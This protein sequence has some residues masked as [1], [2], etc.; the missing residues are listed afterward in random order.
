M[1]NL[2]ELFLIRNLAL[3]REA[4]GHDQIWGMRMRCQRWLDQPMGQK[5]FENSLFVVWLL[6]IPTPEGSEIFDP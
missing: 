6:K 5:R 1:D 4:C 3:Q 2:K